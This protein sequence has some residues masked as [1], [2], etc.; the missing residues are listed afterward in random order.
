[1]RRSKS[2]ESNQ[3]VVQLFRAF[4]IVSLISTGCQGT[5]FCHSCASVAIPDVPRELN[6]VSMPDYV[7]EPPDI[8]QIEAV[9][10]VPLPPYR[11]EPLDSLAI[12]VTDA[13]PQQP[14]QGTY[15]VDPD[16]TINLGFSYGS[17]RVI[18]QTIEEA[19]ASIE[20]H[21]KQIVKPGYQVNVSLAETRG[22][23]LITGPHLVRQDGKISLGTYGSVAVAGLTLDA[24]KAAVERQ[25]SRHL[26]KPEVSIDIAGYNSK[27]FYVITDNAGYGEAVYRLPLT[28]NDTVLDAL[29]Q[30]F[31]LPPTASKKRIWVA[32]PVP[33]DSG[34]EQILPVDWCAIT[35][36]GLTDSNY[37]ILPG[38]RIY[39]Q[40]QPILTFTA[41][42][43]KTI[44]P[45]E[46]VFGIVL[47]GASTVQTIQGRGFFGN[48]TGG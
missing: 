18:D 34:C 17:V 3:S 14:I 47:L 25:L 13:L 41:A 6:K 30:T 33:A 1:M 39:V 12:Y 31:G 29:S 38:D 37:Q 22:K 26:L 42:L 5:S 24:A 16:G 35:Q 36:R 11:I 21:L 19:K 44:A 7:I 8:L 15:P 32:R 2:R 28:G 27:V 46:R 43:S 48:N 10:I 45:I 9:R 23:Q 4:C 20:N 40:S